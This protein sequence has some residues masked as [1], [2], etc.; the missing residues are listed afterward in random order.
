MTQTPKTGRARRTITVPIFLADLLAVEMAGK[1]PE[2]LV[3]ETPGGSP[4]RKGNFRK[5][6][7]LP[8]LKRAGLEGLRVHDYA[9][10]RTSRC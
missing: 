9:G 4:L 8:A 5:R 1:Q 10:T 3:F 2:D 6:V 7:W